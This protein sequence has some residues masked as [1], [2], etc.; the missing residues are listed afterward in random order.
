MKGY[1]YESSSFDPFW[2]LALEESFGE[3]MRKEKALILYF[4]QND[5]T[6]VIGRNQNAYTECNLEYI[7]AHR[8]TVAR[9]KTGGGAVYHDLGNLN[10]S[11]ILP[12]EE[13]DKQ[14]ST[15][16]VV[17]GLHKAG[18]PAEVNGRNDILLGGKKISGNA[19]YSDAFM[20]LH[21]GTI[22]FDVDLD[23]MTQA[24]KVSG[25]KL[26]KRGIQSVRSRVAN[27]RGLCPQAAME[28]VKKAI[29]DSFREE[30]AAEFEPGIPIDPNR[31]EALRAKYRSR[32]WVY[33]KIKDYGET[34]LIEADGFLL[35]V[36]M[37]CS[38]A[39]V[40]RISLASDSLDPD[41]IE[42]KERILNETIAR[43]AAP[44]PETVLNMV[45]EAL[46]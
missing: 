10:Y 35:T 37:E 36:S 43:E 27:L 26:A 18:I 2:N 44:A 42:R 12:I 21:H 34:H 7:R 40:R 25:A 9:R 38:G 16:A 24:L 41:R 31:V 11:V 19:Y 23:V 1:L 15:R 14:R 33:D 45:K 39:Y 3:W 17:S 5:R 22:L 4:W 29:T 28:T 46:T 30:Y 8:I 6:V 20:G 13:Y 32:E